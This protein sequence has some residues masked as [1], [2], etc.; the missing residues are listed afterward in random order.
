MEGEE[1]EEGGERGRMNDKGKG[2]LARVERHR[3]VRVRK[4]GGRTGTMV[5]GNAFARQ[6]SSG[7]TIELPVRGHQAMAGPI[8]VTNNRWGRSNCVR[9]C[10]EACPEALRLSLGG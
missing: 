3:Q 10:A 7:D 2:E 1:E 6:I 4:G 5:R 9:T 8:R